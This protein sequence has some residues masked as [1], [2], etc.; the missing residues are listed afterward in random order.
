MKEIQINSKKTPEFQY[1]MNRWCIPRLAGSEGSFKIVERLKEDF[2]RFNLEL[3]EQKF[4]VFKSNKLFRYRRFFFTFSILSILFHFILIYLFWGS[5][6]VG[7]VVIAYLIKSRWLFLK[8]NP[9]ERRM[10]KESNPKEEIAFSQTNLIYRLK[11]RK[12]KRNTIILIAHHDSKS[13]YLSTYIR[14]YTA[15]IFIIL[16]FLEMLAYISVF[17]FERQ[18]LFETLRFG[19]KIY[20]FIVGWLTISFFLTMGSNFISNESPGALDNASGLYT[21]WKTAQYLHDSPL[22]NTELW[23]VLTGA[24]EIDQEGAA[25]FLN[26]YRPFFTQT[27][28]LVINFDMIGLKDNPLEVVD[29]FYIPKDDLSPILQHVLYNSAEKLSVELRGWYLWIG[30]YTDGFLFYEEGYKTINFITKKAGKYTHQKK[31]TYDHI[32]PNLIDA[33]ASLNVQLIRTIDKKWL[34]N[35]V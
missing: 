28:T 26:K 10:E 21:L 20:I 5:V 30:G 27:N 16:I 15:L 8:K 3:T 9:C 11:P 12:K 19:L 23:I 7:I 25:A 6:P 14:A 17:I 34:L 22:D 18:N 29:S 13:Q 2:E 24:E 31:D 33:Q 4:S 1:L 32:D 35:E